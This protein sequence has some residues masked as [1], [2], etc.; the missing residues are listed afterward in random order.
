MVCPF[1][2]KADGRC[3]DRLRLTNLNQAFQF[4]FGSHQFCPLFGEL[5]AE[6]NRFQR[7]H[8]IRESVPAHAVSRSA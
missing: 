6:E 2:E 5:L 8:Q 4:C 1:L 7:L 3:G